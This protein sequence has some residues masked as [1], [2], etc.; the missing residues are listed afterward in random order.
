MSDVVEHAKTCLA[1]VHAALVDEKE[2]DFTPRVALALN[3][4][5][6][7]ALP[8]LVAEVERLRSEAAR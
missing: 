8:N 2:Q 7:D 6:R 3:D 4:L 1:E 5:I